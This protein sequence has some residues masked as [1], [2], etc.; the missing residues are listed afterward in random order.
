MIIFISGVFQK[1]W[2][3]N[4]NWSCQ[5]RSHYGF[6]RSRFFATNLAANFV[7][8]RLRKKSQNRARQKIERNYGHCLV[9]NKFSRNL[10]IKKNILSSVVSDPKFA[11]RNCSTLELSQYCKRGSTFSSSVRVSGGHSPHRL[12][13]T[14]QR[15]VFVLARPTRPSCA[16]ALTQE[17][18]HWFCSQYLR[19]SCKLAFGSDW[20]MTC[21]G[22]NLDST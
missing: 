14:W 12:H 4:W 7:C 20:Q 16:G 15:P 5:C 21:R 9:C 11:K 1:S 17:L 22:S 18:S 8:D 2:I 19:L 6:E 10:H 3:R 13:T